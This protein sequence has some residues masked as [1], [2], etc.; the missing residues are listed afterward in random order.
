[1][2]KGGR[3]KKKKKIER[4]QKNAFNLGFFGVSD[5]STVWG[6]GQGGAK[7]GGGGVLVF[8][9]LCVSLSPFVSR[10]RSDG[11]IELN[12]YRGLAADY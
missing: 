2:I 7:W 10:R 4:S 1:M 9:G 8:T 6:G 5:C 12:L 11:G 3:E